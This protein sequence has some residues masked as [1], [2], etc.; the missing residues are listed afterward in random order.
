MIRDA[1]L[2]QFQT[3]DIGRSLS[4]HQNRTWFCSAKTCRLYGIH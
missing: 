1:Q 2:Y 3:E 4:R